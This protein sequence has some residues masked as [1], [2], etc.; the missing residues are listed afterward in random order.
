MATAKRRNKITVFEMTKDDFYS[1]NQMKTVI[2]KRKKNTSNEPV[3]RLHM[4]HIRFEKRLSFQVLYKETLRQ[5]E[6]FKEVNLSPARIRG[7]PRLLNHTEQTNS[8]PRWVKSNRSQ[9]KI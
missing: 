6:D 1:T 7:R 5:F 3:N 2:T 8:L 4:Q 9:K